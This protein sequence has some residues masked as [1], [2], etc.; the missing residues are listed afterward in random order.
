[1]TLVSETVELKQRGHD[2]WGCCPFH[3]EK[4]P[5]FHINPSTGLWKCFGCGAGGDVFD[6]VM[7]RE[8]LDFPDAI[9]YLAD[10]AGIELQEERGANRGPRRNR[11]IECLTEAEKYYST[12]LMRGRGEGPDSARRYFA[13][14]GYG[15][16]I[17]RSWNLGYAPGHGSLVRHLSSKGF[18]AQE[19]YAADLAVERN[20][21]ASDRFYDRVM[22]PIHDELGRTIAFGGR[23]L[24]DAKPKYLNTKETTVFH[25]GKHLFA[26]DRAKE[27]IAARG[28]AIVSEGYTDVVALHEAGYT[29][30]VA[31]LGTSFSLDHVR[32]LSRFA[33]TIVC[34]FDGD[35]AGQKAAE[36]AIQFIDKTEAD[37]RCVVL[38]D[39][40]DPA[41]FLGSHQAQELQPIIDSARPLMDFVLEKRLQSYDLGSPG[42]RVAA[43]NDLAKLLSPLKNSVLLDGYATQLADTLNMDRDEVKRTIRQTPD[44]RPEPSGTRQQS[45]SAPKGG[46]Y[47]GRYGRQGGSQTGS[48]AWEGYEPVPGPEDYLDEDYYVD[49]YVPAEAMGDVPSRPAMVDDGPSLGALSL[50][51]RRQ[52]EVERELLALMASDPDVVR[53]HADRIATFSWADA[54]NESMA[55]AMLATPEGSTP[56]EV[57]AAATAVVPQAPRLLASGSLAAQDGMTVEGKVEFLMCSLELYSTR[58]K[59]REIRSRLRS[60]GGSVPTEE[61]SRLFQEA[62]ELQKRANDLGRQLSAI[63]N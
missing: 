54:R 25:K 4:S 27:S 10:R 50:D 19:M 5:S 57:V 35:A 52:L 16:A 7:K 60:G 23:V 12:M 26:F 24:T 63:G 14:R 9:R 39:N 2:F 11:L 56:A 37:L 36:R 20:G 13:G 55:W 28:L 51:E 38:P 62:T 3:H 45:G 44:P 29:N 15:S 33:K 18:S 61:T 40:Q 49:D 41:E 17:C 47:Q 48:A 58:R 59:I 34:M 43:L 21:R 22:F 46:R 42:R 1:M 32:T 31:A 30:A 53:V 6:Y 8:S